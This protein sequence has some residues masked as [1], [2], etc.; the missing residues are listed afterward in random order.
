[1]EHLAQT[2]KPQGTGSSH[3]STRTLRVR[4]QSQSVG[5]HVTGALPGPTLLVA[6]HGDVVRTAYRRILAL[7][8]LPWIK[9]DLIL[10]EL[11]AARPEVDD[12]IL[13]D[14]AGSLGPIDDTLLLFGTPAYH[15]TLY[16]TILRFCARYG[17]ISGRGVPMRN[18]AP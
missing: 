18:P 1:M 17:M 13:D 15:L 3:V 5:Y 2:T 8:N 16:W 6:G 10:T 14:V 11:N 7:P 9:G 12:V 4:A